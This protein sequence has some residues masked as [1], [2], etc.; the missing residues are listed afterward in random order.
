M[1][2]AALLITLIATTTHAETRIFAGS[3]G[4]RWQTIGYHGHDQEPCEPIDL[5]DPEAIY[6]DCD[7][8]DLA[9]GNMDNSI[10]YRFGFERD[11][12]RIFQSRLAY[13]VE[14]TLMFTEYN[15]SQHDTTIISATPTIGAAVPLP[16]G[17]IWAEAKG[18]VGPFFTT[19]GDQSGG[20]WFVE[21]SLTLPVGRGA[22]FRIAYRSTTL[23]NREEIS[24]VTR[25]PR[26]VD[27][28]FLFVA[29]PSLHIGE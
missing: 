24:G 20:L 26:V 16:W 12:H 5:S 19:D 9:R 3:I 25:L 1:L 29:S 8:N 10:G 11:F 27:T 15:L 13:G 22:G 4:T 2:R 14:S 6:P 21:T 7:V 28:S 18:G 23:P 17:Q